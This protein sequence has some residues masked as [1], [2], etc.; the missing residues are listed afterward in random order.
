MSAAVEVVTLGE[1]LALFAQSEPG[2]LR[3]GAAFAFRV[4]GAE[5]NVAVGLA[6]LG[7][8]SGW[9]GRVG[10]D[11]FGDEIVRALRGEGV[12]VRAVR[13][14]RRP[15]GLMVRDVRTPVHQRVSYF[16]SGSAGSALEPADVDEDLVAA[17][18][19]LHVTGITLAISPSAAAAVAHAVRVAR[20]A[21]VLVSLDVNFR[22]RLWSAAE[23]RDAVAGLL[24]QVDLLFAGLDE[25]ALVLGDGEPG[26]DPVGAA[27][28]LQGRGPAEVVIK[29]GDRGAVALDEAGNA[30]A[31]AVRVPVVDTVGA[32]DAFVAGYLAAT[33]EGRGLVERLTLACATG[34]F[35]CT[36]VG[37]WE[38]AAT[39]SDLELLQATDPVT[40]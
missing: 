34:A 20:A 19:V 21:G 15:T 40:R 9:T 17:A 1:T 4:G 18:R 2:V 30:A 12:Q 23:A 27:R 29:L 33:L 11:V 28:R 13:D 7:V 38:G 31:P 16:R 39:R 10:E 25:A 5:S 22:S 6:R 36:S 3:S 37:D 14:A 32:G 26:V 24:P 8:P 35:M